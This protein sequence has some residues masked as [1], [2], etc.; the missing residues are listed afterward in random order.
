MAVKSSQDL[1]TARPR[2]ATAGPA[3]RGGIVI[4]SCKRKEGAPI[5]TLSGRLVSEY[6]PVEFDLAHGFTHLGP[7]T[8]Q[9]L[10]GRVSSSV[11]AKDVY[12]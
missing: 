4:R 11:V 6:A 10:P 12:S 5:H 9:S 3:S 1:W 7:V 2:R 8:I